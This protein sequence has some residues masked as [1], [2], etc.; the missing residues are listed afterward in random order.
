MC[1][2]QDERFWINAPE[3]MAD[4]QMEQEILCL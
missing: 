4:F 2:V 3:A 1:G